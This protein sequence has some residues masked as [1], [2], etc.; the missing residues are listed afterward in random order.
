MLYIFKRMNMR[1]RSVQQTC[2]MSKMF[3]MVEKLEM[4]DMQMLPLSANLVRHQFQKL[5]ALNML[6]IPNIS[7]ML[8][9]DD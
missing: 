4:I 8:V 5:Q 3:R 2:Q 7:L 1:K 6:N 9:L